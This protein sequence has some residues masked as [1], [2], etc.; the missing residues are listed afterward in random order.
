[1]QAN[2]A[3]WPL[4]IEFLSIN[5]TQAQ[6]IALR[7]ALA[8]EHI[9][10][11]RGQELDAQVQSYL[12]IARSDTTVASVVSNTVANLPTVQATWDSAMAQ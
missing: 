1:M 11:K 7:E 12:A 8:Q 3:A 10:A 9:A 6:W 5:R 2:R 4:P